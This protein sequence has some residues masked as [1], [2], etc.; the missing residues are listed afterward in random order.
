MTLS[1][2]FPRNP[3][4][5]SCGSRKPKS[6]PKA[7]PK[8]KIREKSRPNVEL[9]KVW[10]AAVT[11]AKIR[12]AAPQAQLRSFY[13][14]QSAR[15]R[16]K[17]KREPIEYEET[18]DVRILPTASRNISL[19]RH[20]R[21]KTVLFFEKKRPGT[22]TMRRRPNRENFAVFFRSSPAFYPCPKSMHF[23]TFPFKAHFSQYS[24]RA[25]CNFA[26]EII[27]RVFKRHDDKKLR[28]KEYVV[29]WV[30]KQ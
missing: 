24:P 13:P 9:R 18:I 19:N 5:H 22:W 12:Q 1:S 7:R 15:F 6:H 25:L 27:R 2:I 28:G 23:R 30:V 26:A 17:K 16:R 3:Q 4:F 14:A 10:R 29:G 8:S 11:S 21:K 20:V